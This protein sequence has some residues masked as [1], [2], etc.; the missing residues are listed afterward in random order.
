MH[1]RF[2]CS[3]NGVNVAVTEDHKQSE[4]GQKHSSLN[5]NSLLTGKGLIGSISA[6]CIYAFHDIAYTEVSKSILHSN[7]MDLKVCHFLR[8]LATIQMSNLR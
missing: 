6:I 2:N 7:S 5:Q 3:G 8:V 4:A 1:A